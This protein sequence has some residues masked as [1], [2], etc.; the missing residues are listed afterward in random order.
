[1]RDENTG[2]GVEDISEALC[3][4]KDMNKSLSIL[5]ERGKAIRPAEDVSWQERAEKAE[6]ALAADP[7]PRNFCRIEI[8][9]ALLERA[10]KAEAEL[11]R[12]APLL[13]RE[14]ERRTKCGAYWLTPE[15][16]KELR[17]S[18][19]NY[20]DGNAVLPLL[21]ALEKLEGKK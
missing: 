8:A 14:E 5:V 21:D 19:D 10:E 16:R 17:Q 12:M 4:L 7:S 18:F 13:K 20:N 1:M 6:T 3:H 15:G 11:Q 2:W 9:K